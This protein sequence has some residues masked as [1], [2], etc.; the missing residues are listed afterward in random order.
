[1]S[2]ESLEPFKHY[3]IDGGNLLVVVNSRCAFAFVKEQAKFCFSAN[4]F[5]YL[6]FSKDYRR[7]FVEVILRT[8]VPKISAL[9]QTSQVVSLIYFL[10]VNLRL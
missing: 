4:F 9:P 7:T 8:Y 2:Q 1:M 6:V 3:L 5:I 10:L